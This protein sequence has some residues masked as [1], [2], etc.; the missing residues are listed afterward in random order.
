V[1][2]HFCAD[3]SNGLRRDEQSGDGRDENAD[4][5]YLSFLRFHEP[6]LFVIYRSEGYDGWCAE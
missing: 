3:T 2:L 4:N 1:R 5:A 6:I